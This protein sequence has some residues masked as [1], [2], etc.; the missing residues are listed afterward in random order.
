MADKLFYTIGEVAAMF[1]VN[2]SLIR[3]WEK[4]FDN[5]QPSKNSRGDRL[6][7]QENIEVIRQIY[8]LVKKRGYTLDGAR[9]ELKSSRKEFR[10]EAEIRQTLESIKESLLKL[11]EEL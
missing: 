2:T 9:Q 10:K 6:F 1:D 11:K 3:Y 4:E 5:I 8:T 7:T